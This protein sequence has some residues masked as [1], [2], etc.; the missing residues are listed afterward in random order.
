MSI[1]KD[2]LEKE[3]P[4]ITGEQISAFEKYADF[5]VTENAKYNLTAITEPGEMAYKHFADS[6]LP[7]KFGNEFDGKVKVLDIGSG[8]G[9]PGIPL[10]IMRPVMDLTV[11]DAT[12][13]K[14]AF[15]TSACELIGADV[16]PVTARAEEAAA[17]GKY[18]EKYDV[19]VSRGVAALNVLCELCI[20]FVKKEGLF[21]AYKGKSA[22]EEL[23]DAKNAIHKLGGKVERTEKVSTAA[24]ERQ[25]IYIRKI[26]KTPDEYPRQFGKIKKKPL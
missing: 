18:R 1:I 6:V 24:G 13:K 3:I 10:K 8:A 22:D 19:V 11:L 4:D 16:I 9:L 2:V 15:M 20:P 7:L 25:L 12:A 14:V 23:A 21:V 26:V 17:E 5:I